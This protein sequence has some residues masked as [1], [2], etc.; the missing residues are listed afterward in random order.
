MGSFHGDNVEILIRQDDC[1]YE[2]PRLPD[3]VKSKHDDIM[4]KAYPTKPSFGNDSK[5]LFML[6][7]EYTF[8]N[9]GAF[10][11]TLRVAHDFCNA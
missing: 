5:S 11:L 3:I 4:R 1:S 7:S 6:D 2:K 10:G 8:I 9:H